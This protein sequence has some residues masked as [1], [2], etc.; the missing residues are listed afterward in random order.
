MND[1]P[2]I[3]PLGDLPDQ[4]PTENSSLDELGKFALSMF[5]QFKAQDR[6]NGEYI[7]KMGY[8][9][10]LAYEKLA[11]EKGYGHWEK[12]YK[13]KGFTKTWQWQARMLY[14]DAPS[15]E[16]VIDLGLTESL[17]RFGVISPTQIGEKA[18]RPKRKDHKAAEKPPVIIDRQEDTDEDEDEPEGPLAEDESEL[19]EEGDQGGST[20]EQR[21]PEEIE[22]Q[23]VDDHE[24][25]PRK[26]TPLLRAVAIRNALEILLDDLVSGEAD[27]DEELPS[28][29]NEII[30]YA[31][32][33]RRLYE[34]DADEHDPAL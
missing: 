25:S 1:K 20:T 17:I 11:H 18:S 16:A 26:E 14:L 6:K 24:P 4:E 33:A 9:L 23:A 28:V 3:A 8:A 34:N 2:E 32:G 22:K 15:L 13:A 31:E 21:L 19:E 27:P 29:L 10:Q 30:E 12:W 5:N 7:W